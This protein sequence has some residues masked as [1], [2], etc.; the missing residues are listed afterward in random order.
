MYYAEKQLKP[1]VENEIK[2]GFFEIKKKFHEG[3]DEE[4]AEFP[5]LNR[6]GTASSQPNN[7]QVYVSHLCLHNY[8]PIFCKFNLETV[9]VILHHSSIAYLNKGQ[10]LYADGLNE[11]YFYIVLFGKLRLFKK[12]FV[13]G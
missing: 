7:I 9:K 11:Q 5:N 13:E 4:S 2:K 1:E 12:E 3:E 10:T 8:H 6:W